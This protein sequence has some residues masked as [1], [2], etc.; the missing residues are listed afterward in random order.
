MFPVCFHSFEFSSVTFRSRDVRLVSSWKTRVPWAISSGRNGSCVLDEPFR[1]VPRK[2]EPF[3]LDEMADVFAMNH[4]VGCREIV[5][6]FVHRRST[7][8]ILI[9]QVMTRCDGNSLLRS[10]FDRYPTSV[11][12]PGVL[13]SSW[14]LT[15]TSYD[16][17]QDWETLT[18]S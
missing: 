1:P 16:L 9:S 11:L 3:R 4:F 10:W 7:R 18:A 2:H 12:T 17:T 8:Q 15:P 14:L 5:S 6:H 13:E